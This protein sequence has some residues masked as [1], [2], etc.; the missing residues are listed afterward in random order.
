[1]ASTNQPQRLGAV[2]SDLVERYGYRERLDAARAVEAWP[3]VVGED[4]AKQSEQI[5][6]RHGVLHVKVRSAAWRHQLQFQ[7]EAWRD[8]MN[9]HLGGVVVDDVVFR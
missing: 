7:R 6:M 1:M 8:R 5:W 4:I 2:L 3:A 9:E